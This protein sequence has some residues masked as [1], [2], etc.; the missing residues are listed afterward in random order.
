MN[1]ENFKHYN[2]KDLIV[3]FLSISI[4]LTNVYGQ[5]LNVHNSTINGIEI[6]GICDFNSDT[7]PSQCVE[8]LLIS[9]E[10]RT[11]IGLGEGTHGT[12][13]FNKLRGQITKELISKKGF[14]YVCFENNF[15]GAWILGEKLLKSEP[16]N[17]EKELKENFIGIYQTEEIYDFFTWLNEYNIKNTKKVRLTGMDYPE[18]LPSFYL[19]KENIKNVDKYTSILNE[20]ENY[21]SAQD[22]NWNYGGLE[23]KKWIS[24]GLSAYGIVEHLTND[25]SLIP[26]DTNVFR[27]ALLNLKLG[28][29]LIYKYKT[30][31]TDMSRDSAMAVMVKEIKEIDPDAKIVIWAHN[32]HVAKSPIYDSENGG[33]MGS[34]LNRQYPDD[35]FALATITSTGTYSVTKDRYPTRF[36]FFKRVKLPTPPKNSVESLFSR[37]NRDRMVIYSNQNRAF[38]RMKMRFA[39]YN[40]PLK[41]QS[42]FE[43]VNP[44]Q[45]FDTFIYL[46]HSTASTHYHTF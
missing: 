24:N 38:P 29:E 43:E 5:D 15:G 37:L 44:M 39:G 45:L 12:K 2:I 18:L 35:Y 26:I 9:I 40:V 16:L 46:K 1:I 10:K 32:A 6:N 23:S 36:N 25:S 28:F 14:N 4:M 41:K 42:Q 27:L 22:S 17:M 11:I 3:L 21:V 7:L 13:E 34:Y 30:T 31:G 8:E 19:M 20:L 33:G